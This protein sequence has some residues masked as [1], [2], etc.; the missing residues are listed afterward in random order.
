MHFKVLNKSKFIIDKT[1]YE[2]IRGIEKKARDVDPREQ[3]KKCFVGKVIITNYKPYNTYA[4]A[5][6]A[7][8]KT[9]KNVYFSNINERTSVETTTSLLD[10]YKIK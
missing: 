9:P 2:L 10:Y 1:C 8:D 7:F 3:I 5:D 4:V 6:V